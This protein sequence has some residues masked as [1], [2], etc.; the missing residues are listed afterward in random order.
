M[1]SRIIL[2]VALHLVVSISLAQGPGQRII[3]SEDGAG[4]A[5]SSLQNGVHTVACSYADNVDGPGLQVVRYNSVG[6]QQWSTILRLSSG[7]G[8]SLANHIIHSQDGGAVVLGEH[9]LGQPEDSA[10][11][12]KLDA[13]GNIAWAR[14]FLLD[15]PD[16]LSC[17]M[18]HAVEDGD[19]N[20]YLIGQATVLSGGVSQ[21]LIVS[22]LAPDGN[23]L[24]T[25]RAFTAFQNTILRPNGV[26]LRANGGVF[27]Y[28]EVTENYEG[29]FVL[30]LTSDG[31]LV[32]RNLFNP[33]GFSISYALQTGAPGTSD[34]KWFM[35]R[36]TESTASPLY[37]L[38]FDGN[39]DPLS[40]T[41]Y[42]FGG[43]FGTFRAAT[44]AGGSV[45]AVGDLQVTPGNKDVVALRIPDSG[46]PTAMA[47]GSSGNETAADVAPNAQH[48]VT[49]VGSTD[50]DSIL[51]ENGNSSQ[52]AYIIYTDSLLHSADCEMPLTVTTNTVP[53]TEDSITFYL[54]DI[55]G[56]ADAVF[57]PGSG[58]E[59]AQVCGSTV[60]MPET[61][62]PAFA[63][64][65]NPAADR[66]T[67][68]YEEDYGLLRVMDL[69]G[70]E[71]RT[72]RLNGSGRETMAVDDLAPGIYVLL[73]QG[74]AGT[75]QAKL[76]KE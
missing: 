13:S 33:N 42:L 26:S 60:G 3:D 64:F 10:F 31:T 28:G 57:A 12:V 15:D 58:Y 43:L 7:F 47:Y 45:V 23:V 14:R 62:A 35:V 49:V 48:G 69:T 74:P 20:I 16:V 72:V 56:W 67:V 52:V 38:D 76:V 24:W 2:L 59:E 5:V 51:T 22:K 25:K 50:K 8:M 34:D 4:R 11:V 6:V 21:D 54:T 68:R 1:M 75:Q 40:I 63:V 61:S 53:V 36:N 29:M 19:G 46:P 71:W 27:V 73:L 9:V 55:Q 70:S 41:E 44:R 66:A 39:G 65:P 37:R 32:D 17:K 18:E 30:G